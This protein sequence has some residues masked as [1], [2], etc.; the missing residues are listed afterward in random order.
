MLFR[1]Q[2]FI[3]ALVWLAGVILALASQRRHPKASQ[4]TLIAIAIFFVESLVGAYINLYVPFI[5]R[6]R[7]WIDAQLQMYFPFLGIL[8]SLIRAAAWGFIFA[9]IFSRREQP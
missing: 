9:A 3:V 6:D 5:L 7:G 8:L 2:Y 1:S 4:F